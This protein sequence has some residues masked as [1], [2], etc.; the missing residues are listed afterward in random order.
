MKE[1]LT[2]RVGR[3]I[4]GSVNALVAAVENVAPEIVME[5]TI[6]EIDG[7]VDEVRAE[8][9]RAIADRHLASN[10]LMDENGRYEDLS[11]QIELAVTA[12][13]DDL[14]EAGIAEQLDVEA[15]IPILERTIATASDREKELE[16]YIHALQA[17]RREMQAELERFVQSRREAAVTAA[18]NSQVASSE[19]SVVAARVSQAEAAFDRVMQQHSGLSAAR[20]TPDATSA[21]KLM[22]LEELGRRHRIQERLAALKAGRK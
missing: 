8:L 10:R 19:R 3:I 14:A 6:Q 18:S 5:Q 12:G 9:G 7:A 20:S 17:K 16:G 22:E 11:G 15:R 21:T 4:S 13:R 1:G 2:T